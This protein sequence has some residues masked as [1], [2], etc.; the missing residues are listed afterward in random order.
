[1]RSLPVI[2][3]IMPPRDVQLS[4]RPLLK[5]RYIYDG[6]KAFRAPVSYFQILNMPMPPIKR[7]QSRTIGAKSQ[8]TLCVPLYCRQNKTTR[9][10]TAT[11][12]TTSA[13]DKTLGSAVRESLSDF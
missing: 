7:N 1:M 11:I 13:K 8:L 4:F 5:Y 9:I 3:S 12:I 2:L 6:E 10:I